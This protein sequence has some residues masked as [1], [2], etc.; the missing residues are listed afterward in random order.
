MLIRTSGKTR[1]G[2]QLLLTSCQGFRSERQFLLPCVHR[3]YS[4]THGG[5]LTPIYQVELIIQNQNW[6]VE[7]TKGAKR[8]MR[9][10]VEVFKMKSTLV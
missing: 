2:S 8:S 4:A 1:G 3:S 10:K 7:Y 9:R 6:S 5:G